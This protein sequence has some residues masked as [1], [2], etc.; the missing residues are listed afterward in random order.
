M[1][2]HQ[3]VI[4]PKEYETYRD[5]QLVKKTKWNRVGHAWTTNSGRLLFELY[6]FP[7][8]RFF[9]GPE[10]TRENTQTD[11]EAQ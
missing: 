2:Q 4:V 6:L 5:G 7:G 9:I 10:D 1:K 11:Q 8:Q 3:H